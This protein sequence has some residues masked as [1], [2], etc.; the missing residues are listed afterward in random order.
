MP[1]QFYDSILS[2]LAIIK[3]GNVLYHANENTQKYNVGKRFQ[4]KS[5]PED[6]KYVGLLQIIDVIISNHYCL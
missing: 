5:Q 1:F 6:L 2:M 3:N 4:Y